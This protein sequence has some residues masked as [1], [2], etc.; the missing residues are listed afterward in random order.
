ML[1]LCTLVHFCQWF[2]SFIYVAY[3]N[4]FYAVVVLVWFLGEKGGGII[5]LKIGKWKVL[6]EAWS[7]E[8]IDDCFFSLLEMLYR[9]LVN[10]H[11]QLVGSL[12]DNS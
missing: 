4:F 11:Y 9:K 6:S 1:T 5:I 7:M 10:L 3:M 2:V 12:F 8:V